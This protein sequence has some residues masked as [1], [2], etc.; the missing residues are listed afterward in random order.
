MEAREEALDPGK[1]ID[2]KKQISFA[3]FDAR[4]MGKKG[5]FNY[6]Y[7]PQLSVDGDFQIIVGQHVSQNANDKK[8]VEAGL[9]SIQESAGKLPE[10]MSLDNGY[11]SGENLQALEK[12]GVDTYI[13]TDR[14]DKKPSE[15]LEESNRKLVKSD[16]CYDEE[17]D[18]FHCPKGHPLKLKNKETSDKRIYQGDIAACTS[19]PLFSRCSQSKKG[20]A[21]TITTD[22]HE[23]LRE[24]MRRKME[25][26]E[27]K[28]IYKR[29]KVIVEP[30]FGQ[31]KNGGF[32]GFSLRGKEKVAG[33]FSLVCA[34]HNMKKMVKAIMTESVCPAFG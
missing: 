12:S 27:A 24:A 29:R 25:R 30:V 31:I 28:E 21:R 20:E 3:D 15:S 1:D 2:G 23:G 17:Q 8:E 9:E 34:A 10:K 32:R 18:C 26:E 7:N 13:A 4:I 14:N 6:S 5:S 16:F 33:E 11:F 22:K 19:C